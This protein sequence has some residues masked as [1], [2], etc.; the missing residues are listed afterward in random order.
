MTCFFFFRY[1]IKV[2][3][4]I[5]QRLIW[6]RCYNV[7]EK[8]LQRKRVSKALR[9]SIKRMNWKQSL[10][11][12]RKCAYFNF[13]KLTFCNEEITP[14][15]PWLLK[16]NFVMNSLHPFLWSLKN[17]SMYERLKALSQMNINKHSLTFIQI[18]TNTD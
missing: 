3:A 2:D 6:E 17:F 5:L 8:T 11:A 18:S 12:K 14:L 1:L 10:Q 13:I 15:S 9:K 16:N 7:W 4:V